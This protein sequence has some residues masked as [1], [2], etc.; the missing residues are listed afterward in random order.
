MKWTPYQQRVIRALQSGAHLHFMTGLHAHYFIGH[1]KP[2]PTENTVRKLQDANV[3][4][5][6]KSDWRGETWKWT[7]KP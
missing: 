4:T 2:R 5:L 1:I 3:I 6:I 7:V